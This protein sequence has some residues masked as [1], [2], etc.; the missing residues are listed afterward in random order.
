MTLGS[1]H[2]DG[3]SGIK[4]ALRRPSVAVCDQHRLP[5]QSNDGVSG[6]ATGLPAAAQASKPPAMDNTFR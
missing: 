6:L 4:P 2:F 3:K 1:E 5:T